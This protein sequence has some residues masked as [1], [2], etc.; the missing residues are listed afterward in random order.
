MKTTP[1]NA[2]A[3]RSTEMTTSTFE[4]RTALFPRIGSLALL[5]ALASQTTA[6]VGGREGDRCIPQSVGFSHNDCNSGL[7]CMTIV[8]PAS[9]ATCGESYCCP[10]DGTSTN[11]ACNASLIGP[12]PDGAAGICPVPPSDASADTGVSD[13][14]APVSEDAAGDASEDAAGDASE[15]AAGDASGDGPTDATVDASGG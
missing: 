15:D 8:D 2:A 6:C 4:K 14:P 7:T 11:P 5:L 9:G 12:L 1:G 13:A 3:I 10:S